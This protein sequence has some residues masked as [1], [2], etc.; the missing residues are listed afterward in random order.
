MIPILFFC[1]SKVDPIGSF[2]CQDKILQFTLP[3]IMSRSFIHTDTTN[4]LAKGIG[5]VFRVS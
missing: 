3:K 1:A 5:S 2:F 4:S